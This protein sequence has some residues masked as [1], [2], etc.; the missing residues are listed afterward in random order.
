MWLY[1]NVEPISMFEVDNKSQFLEILSALEYSV[2]TCVYNDT[3]IS[4]DETIKRLRQCYG[5]I[6]DF[7]SD[8]TIKEIMYNLYTRN[9][10]VRE[11]IVTDRIPTEEEIKTSENNVVAKVERLH[12]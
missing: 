8:N 12:E 3:W 11:K 10:F 4:E 6:F 1:R 5:Y 2:F 7:I 9:Y